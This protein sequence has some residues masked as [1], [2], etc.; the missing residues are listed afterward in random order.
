MSEFDYGTERCYDCDGHW[1]HFP[2][3]PFYREDDPRNRSSLETRLFIQT[4]IQE[5]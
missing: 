5:G 2:G 4:L 1:K 3:C